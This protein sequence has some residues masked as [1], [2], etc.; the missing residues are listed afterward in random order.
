MDDYHFGYK[1]KVAKKKLRH[2]HHLAALEW[3]TIF[4][5]DLKSHSGNKARADLQVVRERASYNGAVAWA[6]SPHRK[7]L[8][9]GTN[10][11]SSF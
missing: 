3:A 1:T 6:P 4:S 7:R 11:P 9:L 5:F 10:F 8:T 2:G